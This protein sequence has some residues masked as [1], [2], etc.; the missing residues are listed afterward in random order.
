MGGQLKSMIDDINAREAEKGE[1]DGVMDSVVK[2]LGR[3]LSSLEWLDTGVKE[4][5]GRIRE[6]DGKSLNLNARNGNTPLKVRY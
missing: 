2:I 4:V 5:E 1:S 6:L 3:H